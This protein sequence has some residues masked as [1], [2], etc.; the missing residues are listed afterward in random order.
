MAFCLFSHLFI[1][2][3]DTRLFVPCTFYCIYCL[4]EWNSILNKPVFYIGANEHANW[5]TSIERKMPSRINLLTDRMVLRWKYW[6]P[7]KEK[8]WLQQEHQEFYTNIGR[9]MFVETRVYLFQYIS[10]ISSI[11]LVC[12]TEIRWCDI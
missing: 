8:T 6:F 12:V 5:I 9:Y 11:Y 7:L 10:A 3:H 4:C 1:H 2:C